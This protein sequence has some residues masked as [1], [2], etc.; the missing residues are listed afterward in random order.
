MGGPT[1]ISEAWENGP[2]LF[3]DVRQALE[4]IVLE[5]HA[6]WFVG[7]PTLIFEAPI[8]FLA[9]QSP[10]S[11]SPLSRFLARPRN[12]ARLVAIRRV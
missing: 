11:F 9:A 1:L 3:F 12:F 10:R 8:L 2:T 7:T 4:F 6:T 5:V